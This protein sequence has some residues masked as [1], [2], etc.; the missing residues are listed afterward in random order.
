MNF[1]LAQNAN[2]GI[3]GLFNHGNTCYM[4][5]VVQCLSHILEMTKYFVLNKYKQDVFKRISNSQ[6]LC[7]SFSRVLKSLWTGGY[8]MEISYSFKQTIGKRAVQ[9]SG[10]EQHDAHEFLL[11]LLGNLHD[12]MNI[13][14]SAKSK[15]ISTKKVRFAFYLK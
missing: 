12:E 2:A 1:R 11:W 5:A 9:Y 3:V 8:K 4:N 6:E 10:T 13:A 15:K 14:K 7:D